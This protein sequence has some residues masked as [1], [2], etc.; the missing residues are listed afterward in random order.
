LLTLSVGCFLTGTAAADPLF[1]NPVFGVGPNPYTQA[2]AD[3]NGDGFGDLAVS[4]YGLFAE[5]PGS[6][7]ILLGRGDGTFQD[8]QQIPGLAKVKSVAAGFL[9][10]DAVPD[11]AISFETGYP[12]PDAAAVLFGNGDGTF[13]PAQPIP[14][15]SFVDALRLGD[16]NG[17]G[18]TDLVGYLIV[19]GSSGPA[20][21]LVQVQFGNGDGTFTEAPPFTPATFFQSF[22]VAD[23]DADGSADLVAA[24][25][26]PGGGIE[27]N[28]VITYRSLGDGSFGGLASF[29]TGDYVFVTFPAD[30]TG[31]GFVDLAVSS[32][33]YADG[34]FCS[35]PFAIYLGHGNGQFDPAPAPPA[36]LSPFD[37]AFGEYDG[38]GATDMAIVVS[39]QIFVWLGHGDGTF[40]EQ[41]PFS[42]GENSTT[43]VSDDFDGDAITDLSICS[44]WAEAVFTFRGNGDGSFGP[45]PVAALQDALFNAVAAGDLNADGNDDIA[46]GLIG[47]NEVAVLLGNGDGTFL[48]EARFPAGDNPSAL[49]SADL[50]GDGHLDLAVTSQNWY[51]FVPDPPPQGSLAILLGTGDGTFSP[52]PVYATPPMPR[53]IASA[54]L[55]GDA[56][57]DL[58]VVSQYAPDGTYGG[59]ISVYFGS[60]D[61][62]YG[63]PEPADGG[64]RPWTVAVGDF[65]HD[66]IP[67]LAVGNSG[68]FYDGIPGDLSIALGRGDGS[69]DPP[70]VA[71]LTDDTTS[72]AVG[73]FNHDGLDDVAVAD[74]GNYLPENRGGLLA[75]IGQPDGTLL[76]TTGRQS[77]GV[78]PVDVRIGDFD[79]DGHADLAAA[80]NSGDESIHLG[81]GDGTFQPALRFGLLGAPNF[82]V[83]RDFNGDSRPDLLV[84]T[85]GGVYLLDNRSGPPPPLVVNAFIAVTAPPGTRSIVSWSTTREMDLLGFN[86]L[87]TNAGGHTFQLNQGIIECAECTTGEG[88]DYEFQLPQP[89]TSQDIYIEVLHL[90]GATERYG[91]L[92]RRL[93]GVPPAP[94][95]APVPLAPAGSRQP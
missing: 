22:Q 21:A 65:N 38:N 91:P 61:G 95:V 72:V 9:D 68:L 47:T 15:D 18:R 83:P 41:T 66:G 93:T 82:V 63:P 46:A 89:R 23:V 52:A 77:G 16:F 53:A 73:E 14:F 62:S 92:L 51:D 67:D 11:L 20:N 86:I 12:I 76:P 34:C 28:E 54:D 10:G 75:L 79:G 69:F 60:G 19:Y 71:L 33:H 58:I 7:S 6:V 42:A 80:N 48:P 39:Y 31:D 44:N 3:F 2:K 45:A 64:A 90:D 27:P 94:G 87:A 85:Q 29:S 1:P 43:I 32:S 17:D 74:V 70:G 78:G 49:A 37:I 30:L 35:W 5:D 40:D 84:S 81:I 88:A 4:N 25:A 24:S 36:D 8:Q 13:G 59:A 56:A 55:N 26:P 50:N 57:P